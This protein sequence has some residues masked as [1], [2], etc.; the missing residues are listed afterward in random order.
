MLDTPPAV[1]A[2]DFG[3]AGETS[4]RT[5]EYSAQIRWGPLDEPG[6]TSRL[7]ARGRGLVMKGLNH[8]TGGPFIEDWRISSSISSI[9]AAL[10]S[11]AVRVD[12]ASRPVNP[13]LLGRYTN[14]KSDGRGRQIPGR[15]GATKI[16]VCRL[17]SQSGTRLR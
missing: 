5:Q 11:A 2:L 4:Q 6:L 7:A 9:L 8:L 1:H 15:S 10:E 17:Y 14:P 13:F 12:T 3:C 16:T